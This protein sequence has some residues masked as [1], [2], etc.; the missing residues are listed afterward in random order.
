[1]KDLSKCKIAILI[2]LTHK[3]DAQISKISQ[4]R[5]KRPKNNR[6][7]TNLDNKLEQAVRILSHMGAFT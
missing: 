2:D 5:R 1:M 3:Y 4:S 6:I 7:I